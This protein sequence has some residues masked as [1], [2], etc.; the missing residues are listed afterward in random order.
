MFYFVELI[1][2]MRKDFYYFQ[3]NIL[4]TLDISGDNGLTVSV[5]Y[6]ENMMHISAILTNLIDNAI[7]MW[8]TNN[9]ERLIE[10]IYAPIAV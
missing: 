2:I 3:Q 5:F 6:S 10:T 1:E 9:N 4:G 8:T 7:Y